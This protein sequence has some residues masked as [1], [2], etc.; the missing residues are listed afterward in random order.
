[1]VK[2]E[3]GRKGVRVEEV[4][5]LDS[6]IIEFLLLLSISVMYFVFQDKIYNVNI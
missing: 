3:K 5:S 2:E 4:I 6:E 1:M